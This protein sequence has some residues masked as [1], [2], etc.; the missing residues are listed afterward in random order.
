MRVRLTVFVPVLFLSLATVSL[1]QE[2]P[3]TPDAD[4]PA[5][6]SYVIGVEDVLTIS[7]WG[8]TGL[9]R[10]LTVRPDGKISFDLVGDVQ[11]A[12]RTATELDAEITEGLRRF[13]QEP[14]VTVIVDEINSFKVYM[15]G[16]FVRQGELVLRRKTRLLEAI[17]SSGGLT[18]FAKESN[19]QVVREE[20]GRETRLRIDYRKVLSGERPD[21]NIYLRPGDTV[22][23]Y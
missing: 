14:F 7:V 11:A 19:I 21:L 10:K 2:A 1:A 16:E 3:S 8:E 22:I 5:P 6:G 12:G 4:R 18:E 13:I 17:A 9:T 20:E 15:V 23:A